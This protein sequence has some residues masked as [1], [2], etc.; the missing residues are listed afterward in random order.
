[1][2][3]GGFRV[4]LAI[5]ITFRGFAPPRDIVYDNINRFYFSKIS[6]S[7]FYQCL[8]WIFDLE[9]V[10]EPRYKEINRKPIEIDDNTLEI[11]KPKKDTDKKS[12]WKNLKNKIALYCHKQSPWGVQILWKRFGWPRGLENLSKPMFFHEKSMDFIGFPCQNFPYVNPNSRHAYPS[13]DRAERRID[14]SHAS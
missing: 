9:T 3:L 8:F 1:M 5:Q 7:N 13:P 12:S 4:L 10:T 14:G 6:N 11:Q 2:V